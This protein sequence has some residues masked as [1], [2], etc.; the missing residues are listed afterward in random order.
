MIEKLKSHYIARD[1]FGKI[2]L[3]IN[4]ITIFKSINKLFVVFLHS[5]VYFI[6][7]YNVWVK[8]R[9]FVSTLMP[10]CKAYWFISCNKILY[11][12]RIRFLLADYT[13]V[14]VLIYVIIFNGWARINHEYSTLIFVNIV[15]HYLQV[16]RMNNIYPHS[17]ALIYGIL[18]DKRMMRINTSYCN[19][20][21][22]VVTNIILFNHS[23]TIL[24]NKDSFFD[25]FVYLIPVYSWERFFLYFYSWLF[26]ESNYM[27]I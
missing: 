14:F 4:S 13:I 7:N 1:S 23:I 10:Q 20:T 18:N 27:V 22:N 24:N 6:P 26:I 25:I 9:L 8:D 21:L 5:K 2:N 3:S 11:D 15:S 16:T 17:W 12:F 19:I